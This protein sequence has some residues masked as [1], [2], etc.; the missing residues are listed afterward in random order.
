ML[1]AAVWLI[2]ESPRW[3]LSRRRKADALKA[4]VYM[5][6]GSSNEAGAATE[7]ELIDLAMQE[8]KQNHE[9][10]SYVD[11]FKGTNLRCTLVAV[12]VQVLQQAQGNSFTTTYLVIFLQQVGVKQPLLINVAKTAVNLGATVTTFFLTDKIGRRPMMMGGS[13]FMAALMWIVSAT[14]AFKQHE[15]SDSAAQKIIAAI[16][17][18]V[19]ARS[20]KLRG[21]WLTTN[22]VSLR[23]HAGAL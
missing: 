9:A 15:L 14:S 16:L 11:C 22:R 17:L 23:L 20:S 10:T 13:F 19:S 6:K 7:I 5:R 8:E 12:G 1:L 2:P 21:L 4:L 3:L 18:Y